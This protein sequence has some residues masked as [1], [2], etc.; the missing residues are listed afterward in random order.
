MNLANKK[1]TFF[2]FVF[3]AAILVSVLAPRATHAIVATLVQVANT[4][5]NPVPN[6]DV[7]NPAR[8]SLVSS[9]CSGQNI[10]TLLLSCTTPYTVPPAERLVIQ[11]V[12]AN[13]FTPKGNS[14][15]VAEYFIAANSNGSFSPVPHELPLVSEGIAVIADQLYLA[16]NQPVHYYADPGSTIG[17]TAQTTDAS[18]NTS[19]TFQFN[20]YLISY[21]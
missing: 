15:A 13:C 2:G 1:L 11:Q 19:C 8:A 21:P 7:D 9:S 10:G 5:A 3:L 16:N 14:V 12:E 20:G 4:S 6:T 17:F 18:G